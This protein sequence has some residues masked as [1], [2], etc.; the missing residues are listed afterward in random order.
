MNNMTTSNTMTSPRK[1]PT[2]GGYAEKHRRASASPAQPTGTPKTADVRRPSLAGFEQSTFS[3]ILAAVDADGAR[4]HCPTPAAAKA[5][6]VAAYVVD[7]TLGDA[8]HNR[9]KLNHL[10]SKVCPAPRLRLP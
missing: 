6:A 4:R 8:H 2:P 3:S 7:T 1:A 10:H 9:P 5:A